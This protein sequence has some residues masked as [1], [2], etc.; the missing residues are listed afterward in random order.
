[1]S[2]KLWNKLVKTYITSI[3][4]GTLITSLPLIHPVLPDTA[5]EQSLIDQCKLVKSEDLYYL[6]KAKHTTP[7]SRSRQPSHDSL[8]L[9]WIFRLEYFFILLFSVNYLFIQFILNFLIRYYL[10]Y[11]RRYGYTEKENPEHMIMILDSA[12]PGVP[13][14]MDTTERLIPSLNEYVSLL[15]TSVHNTNAKPPHIAIDAESMVDGLGAV[16][17]GTGID[18]HYYPPPSEEEQTFND[19][20]NPYLHGHGSH[21]QP[22]QPMSY[23]STQ[24]HSSQQP[25]CCFCSRLSR[26]DGEALKRCSGCKSVY[27]CSKQCQTA[28]WPNHKSDCKR[29]RQQQ[30]Y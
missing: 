19:M 9:S 18:V 15:A 12:H 24:P 6:K 20:T 27:Y 13:V 7:S 21:S 8:S 3:D 10:L 11:F 4:R 14:G 25:G 30:Q 28:H 23:T 17:E 29:L 22:T 26:A 16:L 5:I 1:M 2:R